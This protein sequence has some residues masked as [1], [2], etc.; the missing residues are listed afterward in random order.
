MSEEFLNWFAIISL[1]INVIL[2]IIS[3]ALFVANWK[4]DKK[5]KSQVKIWMES[6]NGVHTG[7]RRIVDDKWANLYTSVSDVVNA[8]WAVHA[9]AFSLYQSLY[10]E[11][12]LDEKTYIKEQM[13]QRKYTKKMLRKR[14]PGSN[15][16]TTTKPKD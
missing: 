9:P 12:V 8:V 4:A 14:T 16:K 1:A 11:R 10:E 3:V 15:Q 7:L 13:E 2:I 6:A 5:S